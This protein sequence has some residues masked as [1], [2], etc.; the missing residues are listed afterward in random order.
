MLENPELMGQFTLA[1]DHEDKVVQNPLRNNSKEDC[2]TPLSTTN[3]DGLTLRVM[4]SLRMRFSDI[5]HF[6]SS[7]MYDA[8]EH[9]VGTLTSMADE[10]CLRSHYLS[11]LDPGVGKTSVVKHFVKELLRSDQ[12][13]CV[14]V[15]ICLARIE[16]VKRLVGDMDL[17]ASD[18]AVLTSDD[19]TKGLSSTQPNEARILFTTQQMVRTRCAGKSFAETS[20][21][22]YK[23]QPRAIRVWDEE[24]LPGEVVTLS[25]D[26]LGSLLAPLRSVYPDLAEVIN[27]TQQMFNASEGNETFLMPDVVKECGV[28]L[29][30]A[31]AALGKRQ[32]EQSTK[33]EKGVQD[34]VTA[35]YKLSGRNVS[36]TKDYRS[37]I[38][39]LDIRETLPRDIA[40]IVILDA[41]GRIRN[42]YYLWEKCGS[43]LTRLKSAPKRYNNLTINVMD[44]GGSKYAWSSY[45]DQLVLEVVDLINSKPTEEW[46]VIHP[47]DAQGGRLIRQVRDLVDGNSS[48]VSSVH[49]GAHQ[50]T[51]V[52]SGITNVILAGTLFLPE[53]QYKGLTHLCGKVP[54]TVD[55]PYI[56]YKQTELGEHRHYILQALCRA[57]VRGSR[58]DQCAPCNAYIIASK[59][60]GIR[61]EL[62]TIFPECKIGT[63]QAKKKPV[64]GQKAKAAAYVTDFFKRN[65][66]GVLRLLDL[67]KHLGI[68]DTTN[69]R[70]TI[71]RHPDFEAY[72]DNLGVTECVDGDGKTLNALRKT[73]GPVPGAE[74]VVDI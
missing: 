74:Y 9:V 23:D 29:V 17:D 20:D 69:F 35:F 72:L 56:A 11:S 55:L 21:F 39:A 16:E 45:G 22:H 51:N 2:T 13:E 10:F 50:A 7:M 26:A 40:P 30:D 32:K 28:E 67:R 68:V 49:W 58:G 3:Q 42:T 4:S 44:R 61:G 57:S 73:F 46:L 14:S 64:K 1:D 63:W 43:N 52:F 47:K 71:R 33:L 62:N 48:R 54:V 65:P 59:K 31:Q 27:L 36:L 6:P 66:G 8:M 24:M 53:Q 60:S 5:D 70:K 15:L 41:S 12:Y 38:S 25:A 18:F 19:E 37:V 34:A